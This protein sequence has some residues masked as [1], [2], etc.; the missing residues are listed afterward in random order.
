MA[1]A[2]SWIGK[3]NIFESSK[4]IFF[5]INITVGR[6]LDILYE[7]NLE[8]LINRLLIKFYKTFIEKNS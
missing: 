5:Q 2:G 7:D 6:L 1:S 4:K 3:L 8:K